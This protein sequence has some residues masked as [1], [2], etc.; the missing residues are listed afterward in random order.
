MMARVVPSPIQG[1]ADVHARY[2]I[3]LREQHDWPLIHLRHAGLHPAEPLIYSEHAGLTDPGDKQ[4]RSGHGSA[5]RAW[6]GIQ[7]SEVLGITPKPLSNCSDRQIP[8]IWFVACRL[9]RA[10]ALGRPRVLL[11]L[12]G[13]EL[14]RRIN[15]PVFA[16]AC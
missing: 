15:N 3:A 9:I 7:Q 12:D 2:G 16:I 10:Q 11:P 13:A 5:A 1:V 14:C 4:E 6:W 8:L